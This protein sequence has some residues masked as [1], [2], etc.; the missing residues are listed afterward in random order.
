MER[1]VFYV[2]GFDPRGVRFY[3]QL[4]KEQLARVSALTGDT[5]AQSSRRRVSPTRVDWTITNDTRDVTTHYSFLRWEDVVQRAWIRQPLTLFR[6]AAQAYRA[7]WRCLDMTRIAALDRGTLVTLFYPPIFTLLLPLLIALPLFGL[8]ALLMPWWLALIVAL[9]VGIVAA[10]PL[11]ASLHAPWLLR[12]F[13]FNSELCRTDG[14]AAIDERVDLF[15]A[16]IAGALASGDEEVLLVTH[17]N[18]SILAVPLM[19][20]L[21]E[22]LGGTLPDRFALVTLGHCI[23]LVACRSDAGWFR[24][25]LRALGRLSFRW[26]DIGSP[27]DGAAFYGV[28]PL[29]LVA[30]HAAT[31]VTLLSPRF[32]LFYDPDTYHQGWLNKYEI[33]FDYLRTGDRAS[34]LDLP[35]FLA[36]DRTV[37]EAVAAFRAI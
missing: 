24:E 18:G 7:H 31:T 2:G 36:A 27:P 17:S 35:S 6:R 30:D 11:L 8:G 21:A 5:V 29:L 22:R 16:D 9:M 1:R 28:D 33:H 26:I 19:L 4:M 20:R 23:P 15:A 14:H 10:R 32:H 34:P 12:F 13:V 25:A 37:D 3:H